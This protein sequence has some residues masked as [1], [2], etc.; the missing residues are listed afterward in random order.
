MDTDDGTP[1]RGSVLDP[2]KRQG[3]ASLCCKRLWAEHDMG[4]VG[5]IS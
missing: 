4:K 2:P 5:G 1:A 3:T